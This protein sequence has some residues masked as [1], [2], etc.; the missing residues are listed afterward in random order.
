MNENV[1]KDEEKRDRILLFGTDVAP[2]MLKAAE[3][4]KMLSRN[5][6][7]N[8]SCVWSPEWPKKSEENILRSIV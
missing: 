6:P 3:G 4:L 5:G 2:Y 1:R 8:M 7:L